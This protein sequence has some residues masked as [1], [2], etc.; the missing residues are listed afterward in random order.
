M[1]SDG[2]IEHSRIC[3]WMEETGFNG[4][5]ELEIF[6][7]ENWWKCDCDDFVKKIFP[8]IKENL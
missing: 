8:R 2:L 4:A 6:S 7:N 3:T 5:V 1:P